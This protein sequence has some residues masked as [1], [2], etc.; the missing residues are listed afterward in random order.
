LRR[1]YFENSQVNV[2]VIREF[3]R[4]VAR[5]S[6]ACGVAEAFITPQAA[7]KSLPP[8]PV[9]HA[10]HFLLDFEKIQRIQRKNQGKFI[11]RAVIFG[12]LVK[13]VLTID[14]QKMYHRQ[15]QTPSLLRRPTRDFIVTSSLALLPDS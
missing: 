5:P 12:I 3:F 8:A 2:N 9:S 14:C 11:G 10:T 13:F 1:S 6:A 15:N 7:E 4:K